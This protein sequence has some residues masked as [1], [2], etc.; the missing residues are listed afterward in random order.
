MTIEQI[1]L[2]V[3]MGG[4]ILVGYIASRKSSG[5]EGFMLGGREVGPAVTALT[6]QATAMSG[7]MFMGGPALSYQNGYF[8]IWY[9]IG[10]AG[11]SILNIGILGRRMRSLS[12]KLGSLT[13]IEYLEN[14]FESPAIRIYGSII[15][16]TFLAAYI[17]GQFIAGG[18]AIASLADLS[19]PVAL[20]IGVI[21][22]IIY[23]MMGGYMA[24]VWNDFIQGIVMVSSMIGIAVVALIKIGGITALNNQLG[25]INPDLLGL[26]GTNPAYKNAWGIVIGAILLYAIGYMGLPHSVVRHMSMKST[27][28]AKG[29]IA[30]S[31]IWNQFFVYTPYFLGMMGLILLPN[32]ADPEMVIPELAYTVFPGV[33]AAIVMVALMAAVLSTADSLLIQAGSI[34]SKDIYERFFN[35]N[36]TEKQT[37]L[38]SRLLI[39]GVSI[40]GYIVAVNE[41]PSVF[42]IIVFAFGTLGATFIVPYLA[43]VY[44]RNANKVQVLASMIGGSVTSAIWTGFGLEESLKIHGFFAGVVISVLCYFVFKGIGKDKTPSDKVLVAFDEMIRENMDKKELKESGFG[45]KQANILLAPEAGSVASHIKENYSSLD[46]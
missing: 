15:S 21:V 16:I 31:A 13:P 23:T 40:V 10:D 29:A 46:I 8:G 35:P 25:A 28:T 34:L 43:A 2:I 3:Y 44:D 41:P 4:L 32:L 9:A 27:K 38:A 1:V 20:G 11:G 17:F 45:K 33:F 36:A 12:E 7:Y 37:L 18:K 5:V 42:G 14:R 6:M 30:V 39:F 24:V 22:M 26:W 19:Y